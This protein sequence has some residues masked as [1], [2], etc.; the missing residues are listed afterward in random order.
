M[1]SGPVTT[2]ADTQ[3]GSLS[4]HLGHRAELVLLE[5]LLKVLFV[6]VFFVIWLRGRTT[7]HDWLYR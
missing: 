7:G 1:V 4:L 3:T 5:T 2:V 6:P